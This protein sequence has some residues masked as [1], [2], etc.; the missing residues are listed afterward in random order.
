MSARSTFPPSTGGSTPGDT[1]AS[2]RAKLSATTLALHETL[3]AVMAAFDRHTQELDALRRALCDAEAGLRV[4]APAVAA[5][6]QPLPMMPEFPMA[7]SAPVQLQAPPAVPAPYPIAVAKG[8]PSGPMMTQ[9]LWPSK[10]SSAMA[11][12][13]APVPVP[14]PMQMPVQIQPQQMAPQP[15][16]APAPASRYD[17]PIR[18]SAPAIEPPAPPAP[19]MEQA[20]LEELNA[21]LAYAFSQVSNTTSLGK[22]A[23]TQM[24][25]SPMPTIR[26]GNASGLPDRY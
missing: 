14:M 23:V 24:M 20:T 26:F 15:V 25:P 1:V 7:P 5:V 11:M 6:M 9:I 18:I 19:D 12:P 10:D 16:P 22:G 17:T 21:A 4:T 13:M 2:L 8:P 3:D